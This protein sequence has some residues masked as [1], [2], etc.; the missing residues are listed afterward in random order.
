MSPT[1]YRYNRPTQ[2]H[3]G[4]RTCHVALPAFQLPFAILTIIHLLCGNALATC[5]AGQPQSD[6]LIAASVGTKRIFVSQVDSMLHTKYADRDLSP[7]LVS[8]LRARCLQQLVDQ[9]VVLTHLKKNVATDDEVDLA[10]AR[11]KE[12]LQA[13]E[14]TLDQHLTERK[15]S[16]VAFRETMHW[17]ISWQRY[18]DRWLTDDNLARHFDRNRARLSGAERKV[19]HLLLELA[20]DAPQE[21]VDAVM[22]LANSLRQKILNEEVTWQAAVQDHSIGRTKEEAGDLGWIRIDGPMPVLFGETAYAI[23]LKTI[24]APLRSSFGIH[25]IRC[26]EQRGGVFNWYDA[27]KATKQDAIRYLFDQLSNTST[28]GQE[29]KIEFTGHCPYLDPDTG[30]LVVDPAS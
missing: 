1:Y 12:E 15:V 19:A 23:E 20:S 16:M 28:A 18:L 24:S 3:F 21:Q 14:K 2:S 13:I 22:Q 7:E 29:T 17:Q 10:V 5:G 25:L 4:H 27:A 8:E 6:D 11:L 30:R 9:Q 26:D